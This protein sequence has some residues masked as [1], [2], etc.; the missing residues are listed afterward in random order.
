MS[1]KRI[2]V[3]DLKLIVAKRGCATNPKSVSI[4]SDSLRFDRFEVVKGKSKR[5]INSI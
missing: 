2:R 1:N 5:L 3:N 4:S